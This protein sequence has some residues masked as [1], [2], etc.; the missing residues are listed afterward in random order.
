M[1]KNF[2]L[3]VLVVFLLFIVNSLSVSAEDKS[4]AQVF[5]NNCQECHELS[6]GCELLGQPPKEWKELF[7]FMEDMGADLPEAE[8]ALLVD[9]LSKPDDAT[10]TLCK[11]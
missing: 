1:F 4:C 9:C 2:L 10:K 11:E 3:L 6:R 8:H 5:E 7:K